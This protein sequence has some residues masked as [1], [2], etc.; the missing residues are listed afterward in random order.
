MSIREKREAIEALFEEC[1]EDISLYHIV[2]A[3]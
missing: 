1:I 2:F 3:A